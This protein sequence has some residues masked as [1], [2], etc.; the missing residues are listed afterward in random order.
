M[1]AVLKTYCKQFEFN[2]RYLHSFLCIYALRQHRCDDR[3]LHLQLNLGKMATLKTTKNRFVITNYRL[4]QLKRIAEC[5][6]HPIILSSF[7]NFLLVIKISVLSKFEWRFFTG[8]LYPRNVR[9][10]MM[11]VVLIVSVL[12]WRSERKYNKYFHEDIM[13][14]SPVLN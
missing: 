3:T 5:S 2:K 11:C 10:K 14:I 6:E 8:I 9:K 4:M 1:I 7:I 13:K 12:S